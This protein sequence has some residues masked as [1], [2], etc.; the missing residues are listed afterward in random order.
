MSC[1]VTVPKPGLASVQWIITHN[2]AILCSFLHVRK[3]GRGR[4]GGGGMVFVD[5][6]MIF[7]RSRSETEIPYERPSIALKKG[8][9]I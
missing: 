1:L 6:H 7:C 3:E 2:R 8:F 9:I 4:G 5:L